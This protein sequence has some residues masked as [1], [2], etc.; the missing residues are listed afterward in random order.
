[1]NYQL[2]MQGDEYNILC[3]AFE[4]MC[5]CVSDPGRTVDVRINSA[6]SKHKDKQ[7]SAEWNIE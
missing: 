7:Y 5:V 4:G 2:D 6:N 3:F 1:M